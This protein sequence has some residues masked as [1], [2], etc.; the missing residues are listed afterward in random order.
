MHYP[1]AR[2]EGW[3]YCGIRAPLPGHLLALADSRNQ[4]DALI[5]R[6]N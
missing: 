5:I 2:Y 1:D 6:D 4:F 3:L